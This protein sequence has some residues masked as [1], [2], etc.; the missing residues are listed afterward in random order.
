VLWLSALRVDACRAIQALCVQV[1]IAGNQ[2]LFVS[3]QALAAKQRAL[4]CACVRLPA[5]F[6]WRCF[7]TLCMVLFGG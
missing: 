1:S 4:C 5:L 3:F 6:Q 7:I 2:H